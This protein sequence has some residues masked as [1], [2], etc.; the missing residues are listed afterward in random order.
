MMDICDR[1]GKVVGQSKQPDTRIFDGMDLRNA[2]LAGMELEGISFDGT[3]L[4][5]SDLSGADLYGAFLCDSNFENCNLAAADLRSAFIANVSFRNADLRC[6]RFSL[7]NMG[8]RIGLHQV[9]FRGANLDGAD[10]SGAVYDESTTFP[11]GFDA[12]ARGL[13]PMAEADSS[14]RI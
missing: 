10:F 9:D 12:G 5:G 14:S 3:D 6:A 11:E 4:R 8:G 1:D 13:T 7:D 2:F